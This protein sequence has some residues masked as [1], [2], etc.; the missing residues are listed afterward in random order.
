MRVNFGDLL[1][2]FLSRCS[3]PIGMFLAIRKCMILL[4]HITPETPPLSSPST[5]LPE[6]GAPT[7]NGSWFHAPYL[8]RHGEV[9]P[10]LRQ[11]H[12]LVLSQKRY[13]RLLRDLWL[14]TNSNVW[15]TIARR[16]EGEINSG[17]WETL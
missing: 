11:R 4:L 17:G 5:V 8:T 13:D 9:D 6:M 2:K 1:T 7:C 14:T 15:S 12:Q 3:Y 16:L 10:G